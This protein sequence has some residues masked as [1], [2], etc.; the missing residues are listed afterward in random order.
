[1]KGTS[2]CTHS[3]CHRV[4]CGERKI[5]LSFCQPRLDSRPTCCHRVC[6]MVGSQ[7]VPLACAVSPQGSEEM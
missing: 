7:A 6:T 4:S 1:M 3:C 2:L 5:H